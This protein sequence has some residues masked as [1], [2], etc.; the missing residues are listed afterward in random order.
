MEEL[1]DDYKQG[2]R[3]LGFYG[4]AR[5]LLYVGNQFKVWWWTTKM[6]IA[7][8]KTV[9]WTKEDDDYNLEK[10]DLGF[11]EWR[12]PLLQHSKRILGSHEWRKMSIIS[13]ETNLGFYE[14]GKTTIVYLWKNNVVWFD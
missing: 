6:T 7:V 13:W 12:K 1:G 14:M 8:R 11:H 9:S 3:I 4:R 10:T 2:N 5:R